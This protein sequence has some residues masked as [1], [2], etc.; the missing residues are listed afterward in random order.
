[1]SIDSSGI[2]FLCG[3]YYASYVSYAYAVQ[4]VQETQHQDLRLYARTQKWVFPL[5]KIK[6]QALCLSALVVIHVRPPLCHI[7]AF[8]ACGFD[9]SP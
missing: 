2:Y 4:L 7:R 6:F 1:M 8:L 3:V 9:E 5:V